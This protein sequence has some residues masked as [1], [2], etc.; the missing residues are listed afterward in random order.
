MREN[1]DWK[2]RCVEPHFD[3]EEGWA[4]VIGKGL[5]VQV[6]VGKCE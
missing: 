1:V 5:Y 3:S 4:T 6:G 2:T